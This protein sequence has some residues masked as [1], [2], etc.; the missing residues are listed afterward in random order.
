MK[1]AERHMKRSR[2][3]LATGCGE[4]VADPLSPHL[5]GDKGLS[6]GWGWGA[7]PRDAGNTFLWETHRS[8]EVQLRHINFHFW[9]GLEGRRGSPLFICYGFSLIFT[10]SLSLNGKGGPSG[11]RRGT[12]DQA[13]LIFTE[14]SHV[15]SFGSHNTSCLI[16]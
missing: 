11:E 5:G 4:D 7:K 6:W 14:L 2:R 3:L 12:P 8:P 13:W 10:V 9:L 1:K 15:S 16:V